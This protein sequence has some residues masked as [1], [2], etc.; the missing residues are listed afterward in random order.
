MNLSVPEYTKKIQ[1][2]LRSERSYTETLKRSQLLQKKKVEALEEE[3]TQLKKELEKF[4][5]ENEKL[6]QEIEKITKTKERYQVALFDHGN[7]KQNREGKKKPGGG[8]IGHA[9]TNKDTQR[10]YASFVKQRVFASNCSTCGNSLPRVSA[11]KE[12]IL[13]DIELTT[14][15]LQMIIETERQWCSNCKKEVRSKHSQSLPFTEYGINTFMVVLYLR[16]KGKQSQAT[17][18]SMLSGLFGLSISKSG[19][20]TLLNQAKIYLKEKYEQLKQSVR[21]GE[22]MYNDET[23]WRVKGKSAWMWIMANEQLTVYV[24]AE[25]R[26]KGIM[27]QMYGNSNAY[28]MHDGY[29]GYTNTIPKDKHLYCWAHVLRFVHEETI[30]E[31]KDSLASVIKHRLVALY[32]T[33]RSHPEYSSEQKEQILER[34]LG[35][36]LTLPEENPTIKNML[37][38]LRTQKDGLIRALLVT[39]D[40]TNNLAE[41]ELRPLAISR[42]IT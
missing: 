14:K 39:K 29:G 13:I 35:I 21:E 8:Q 31:T 23:G 9:N 24:A 36:L 18:A 10:N 25:S 17:I 6:K 28:S 1:R 4:K 41:R 27:E 15:V 30:L 5:K 34:E 12:K 37:Q 42:N 33:I 26:G 16:F 3:N 40:G 7:F 20:G 2:E 19:V 32:Q 22:L 11:S 38:R